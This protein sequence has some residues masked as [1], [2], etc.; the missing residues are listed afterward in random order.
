MSITEILEAMTGCPDEYH[1]SQEEKN[2]FH[3][4]EHRLLASTYKLYMR[5]PQPRAD[6]AMA[7]V[8][9]EIIERLP[10]QDD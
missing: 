8:M 4:F 1:F 3:V 9:R 2:A 7:R 5:V 6:K 10:P